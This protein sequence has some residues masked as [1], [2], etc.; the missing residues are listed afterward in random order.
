[1]TV[2]F[3][4]PEQLNRWTWHWLTESLTE[5]TFTFDIQKR[6]KRFVKHLTRELRRLKL[7]ITCPKCQLTSGYVFIS[8]VGG[9]FITAFLRL[10]LRCR[11]A[12]ICLDVFKINSF[13]W[14]QKPRH[15]C[16]PTLDRKGRE[17]VR[18]C[19]CL[20][21]LGISLGVSSK[22]CALNLPPNS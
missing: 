22:R 18:E 7:G 6:P 8:A 3:S 20:N 10:C 21:S 17:W 11:L 9:T 5:G 16:S 19:V 14:R 15:W 12:V 2:V 1:M 13:S 4:C